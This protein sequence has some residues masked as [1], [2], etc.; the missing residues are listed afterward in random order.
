MSKQERRWIRSSSLST[1]SSLTESSWALGSLSSLTD[2]EG[3]DGPVKKGAAS[4][5]SP[6]SLTG[7]KED[8]EPLGDGGTLKTLPAPPDR[9]ASASTLGK[10]KRRRPAPQKE[11]KRQAKRAKKRDRGGTKTERLEKARAKKAAKR[12]EEGAIRSKEEYKSFNRSRKI[13]RRN[14]CVFTLNTMVSKGFRVIQWD[15]M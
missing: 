9:G 7:S 8:P 12:A 13:S 6:V 3:D 2:S 10:R 14:R 15:G 1:L 11:A 5:P 4:P